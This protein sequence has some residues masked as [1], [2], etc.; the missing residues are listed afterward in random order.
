MDFVK[1]YPE[2]AGRTETKAFVGKEF[3]K[4]SFKQ[5]IQFA[6]LSSQMLDLFKKRF[7]Y[8]REIDVSKFDDLYPQLIGLLEK[9]ESSKLD[10]LNLK[11]NTKSKKNLSFSEK[12]V[13]LLR[14]LHASIG[15][16]TEGGE[17]VEALEKGFSGEELDFVN[18]AEENGDVDWYQAILYNI[19]KERGLS[20]NEESVRERNVRKLMKRYPDGYAD[21]NAN[22]R[23]LESERKILEGQ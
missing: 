12:D 10:F 14:I 21:V 16:I 2:L 15:V 18:I 22:V 11:G 8:N 13:D 7:F 9:M 3:D 4:E 6:V 20:I 19:A 23:D 5:F 1:D 17:L